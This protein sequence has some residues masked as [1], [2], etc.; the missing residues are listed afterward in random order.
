MS[1]RRAT[2]AD[3]SALLERLGDARAIDQATHRVHVAASGAEEGVAIW[4][5]PGP[6]GDP[7]LGSVKAPAGDRKLFYQLVRACAQDAL[8]QG[9]R[10]AFFTVRD[11][12]LISR[13]QR[14]FDVDPV[15]IGWDA[16]SGDPVE[17]EV[18]V[19]LDDALGQLRRVI[20]G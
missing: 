2:A 15:A 16:D 1:I 17:W 11:H 6:G 19:D 12:R 4:M 14:D 7:Y 3:R 9:Y 8:D 13:I 20:D 10:R 18:H 5:E